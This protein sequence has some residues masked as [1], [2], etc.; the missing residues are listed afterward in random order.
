MPSRAPASCPH[1]RTGCCWPGGQWSR[2][3][4]AGISSAG[5]WN[6]TR[7]PEAAALREAAEETGLTLELGGLLGVY[8]D[9]YGSGGFA[10]LNV[11]FVAKIVA[12][13]PQPHDDVAELTWFS[14]SK[15][16]TEMAFPQHTHQV[17]ADWSRRIRRGAAFLIS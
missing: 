17:L 10:T 1:T 14:Q 6:T 11:Y 5:S 4:V 3:S 2:I 13:D 16:P 12:G 9:V 7:T 15:L 8:H